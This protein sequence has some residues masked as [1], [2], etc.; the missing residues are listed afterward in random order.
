MLR[1]FYAVSVVDMVYGRSCEMF[2]V[3]HVIRISNKVL[4]KKYLEAQV[5]IVLSLHRLFK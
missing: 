2:E 4:S 3:L 5:K 1:P